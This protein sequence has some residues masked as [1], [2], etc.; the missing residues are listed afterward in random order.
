V[1]APTNVSFIYGGRITSS[2]RNVINSISFNNFP[3]LTYLELAFHNISNIN[4]SNLPSLNELYLYYN[5]NLTTVDVSNLTSLS[6]LDLGGNPNI[7]FNTSNFSNLPSLE[8][9][10]LYESNLSTL[11]LPPFPSVSELYLNDNNFTNVESSSLSAAIPSVTLIDFADNNLQELTS[12]SFS[13]LS[14]TNNVAELNLSNNTISYLSD[15]IIDAIPSVQDLNLTYNN[16]TN[17]TSSMFSNFQNLQTLSLSNNAITSAELSEVPSLEVLSLSQNNLTSFEL[18]S[19]PNLTTLYLNNNTLQSVQLSSLASLATLDLSNNNINSLELS[20]F[21]TLNSL[22][23]SYNPNFDTVTLTDLPSLTQFYRLSTPIK[24]IQLSGLSS[25]T[26]LEIV[27]NTTTLAT[28]SLANMPLLNQ[29]VLNSSNLS[30]SLDI[31]NISSLTNLEVQSCVNLKEIIFDDVTSL[32]TVLASGCSLSESSI[33]QLLLAIDATNNL[34]PG[35][36]NFR[37]NSPPYTNPIITNQPALDA[38]DNLIEK[39]WTVFVNT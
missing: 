37:D 32:H 35:T 29:L 21:P 16:I 5:D 14:Q 3:N 38:I 20:S 24:G 33:T 10:Y 34:G 6:A 25:L 18:T 13:G 1:A 22:E 9:L 27:G 19:L 23:L 17:V 8:I 15:S 39:G 11:F 7:D 12:S 28:C 4:L 36:L 30:G 2:D 31:S 26:R